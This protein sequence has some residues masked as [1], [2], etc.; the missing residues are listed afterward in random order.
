MR[1]DNAAYLLFW[2]GL[3]IVLLLAAALGD[4][5]DEA[6]RRARQ[7][8]EAVAKRQGELARAWTVLDSFPSVG[9]E[10]Q[11]VPV[12]EDGYQVSKE[13]FVGDGFRLLP[14]DEQRRLLRAFA[15][16]LSEGENPSFLAVVRD[17]LD[18]VKRGTLMF[19]DYLAE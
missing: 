19:G 17:S 4:R 6:K 9:I 12:T 10:W 14:K 16:A 15:V 3:V 18:G 1:S 5:R 7:S 13:V 11:D 2:G 8:P